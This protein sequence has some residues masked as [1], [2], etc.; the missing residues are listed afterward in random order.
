MPEKKRDKKRKPGRPVT[1]PK[2]LDKRYQIRCAS[3]D[4]A[5]WEQRAMEL[6]FPSASAWI[7][8]IA[9]DALKQPVRFLDKYKQYAF[10]H[11]IR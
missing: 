8:K 4:V 11:W 1:L 10:I 3:S 9:N 6:G 7:R 5:A 2:E